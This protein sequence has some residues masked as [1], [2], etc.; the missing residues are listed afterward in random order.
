MAFAA[1]RWRQRSTYNPDALAG[2][3]PKGIFILSG[4]IKFCVFTRTIMHGCQ[5]KQEAPLVCRDHKDRPPW[6]GFLGSVH[7][8]SSCHWPDPY[9]L[10]FSMEKK[11]WCCGKESL[12]SEI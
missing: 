4:D 10:V 9:L 5:S 7:L 8:P 1:R 3:A 2:E 12:V 11:V 6:L